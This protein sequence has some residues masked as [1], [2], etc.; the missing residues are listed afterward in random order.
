M[1]LV[2]PSHPLD[3]IVSLS[4]HSNLTDYFSSE[5]FDLIG[6]QFSAPSSSF[7]FIFAIFYIN[8][9][10]ARIHIALSE[11]YIQ[12]TRLEIPRSG[13][14]QSQLSTLSSIKKKSSLIRAVNYDCK[15]I[16]EGAQ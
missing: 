2:I 15:D 5:W 7:N 16:R 12:L 9:L 10:F 14:K 11:K 4:F 13:L 3:D 6:A 8:I 1:C